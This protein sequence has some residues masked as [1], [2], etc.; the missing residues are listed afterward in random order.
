[1]R[2]LR[3]RRLLIRDRERVR[4]RAWL[5][6]PPAVLLGVMAAAAA[7]LAWQGFS[8]FNRDDLATSET[9][10]AIQELAAALSVAVTVSL[11]G[12]T[13]WYA[14][15]VNK[16]VRRAGPDVSMHWHLAWAHPSGA[17]TTFAA[18]LLECWKASGNL[19]G[20]KRPLPLF[21]LPEA[22]RYRLEQAPL[23]QALAQ[24]RYPLVA[25]LETMAGIAPLQEALRDKF[26]YMEQEMVQEVSLVV[27]PAGPAAGAGAA[28]VTWKLSNDA[29]TRIVIGAGSAT[30]S[31]GPSYTT[32]EDF[33][34]DF[35][36]VLDALESV[37]VP[38][39]DRLGVRY[40][41]LVPD[42]PH[43]DRAWRQWFKPELLGWAGSDVVADKALETSVNQVT[44][45]HAAVGD[46]AGLSAE[47]QA[48]VRHGSVPT[49]TELPGIPPL[50]LEEPSYFLDLDVFSVGAQPLRPSAILQQFAAFHQQIDAFFYW[51]LTEKGLEHFGISNDS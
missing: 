32:V 3:L 50:R 2:L 19:A 35:S 7:F 6:L 43:K 18:R 36:H 20:E 21:Q 29:G 15:L 26:P 24:V 31:A 1:M 44:L 25:A 12:V 16:Q 41:S 34:T 49:G 11:V 30:L 45:R 46:L 10:A 13:K 33:S 23:A 8:L 48:V 4:L 42:V 22:P 38:R 40:L 51:S 39:C 47:V 14:Y 5:L 37:K 9:G 27:G 28:S 17:S